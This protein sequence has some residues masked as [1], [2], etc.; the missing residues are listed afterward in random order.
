MD[1]RFWG[2]DG[3]QLLHSIAVSYPDNSNRNE[4][5]IYRDFFNSIEYILPCIY[6]RYSFS[7]Y[8]KIKPVDNFLENSKTLSEWLFNIHNMVNNKLKEQGFAVK[9]ELHH[10]PIYN[11]YRKFVEDINESKGNTLL[12]GWDILYC[13]IF[14]FSENMESNRL[15]NYFKFLTNFKYVNPF[16]CFGY[17]IESISK[18]IQ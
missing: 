8:I 15:K 2:P 16:N 17:T 13:I 12:P 14:N 1:T 11:R 10:E 9:F 5:K 6:C 4:K 3:W 7:E 18:R